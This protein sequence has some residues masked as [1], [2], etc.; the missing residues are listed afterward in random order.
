MEAKYKAVLPTKE[1]K[2][3]FNKVAHAVEEA[4]E[5]RDAE[6]ECLYE[7]IV[8]GAY[9]W[10]AP[11]KEE[12]EKR[13]MDSDWYDPDSTRLNVIE[14]EVPMSKVFM[15]MGKTKF[16]LYRCKEALMQFE[17]VVGSSTSPVPYALPKK[18]PMA[19][20]KPSAH[21]KEYFGGPIMVLDNKDWWT[22]GHVCIKGE[23]PKK[24]PIEAG[25]PHF[26]VIEGYFKEEKEE[27]KVLYYCQKTMD[28]ETV[29]SGSPVLDLRNDSC[30]ASP[31]GAVKCT[32]GFVQFNQYYLNAIRNRFPDAEYFLCESGALAAKD[33]GEW[34]AV[35]MPLL[36]EMEL[37]VREDRPFLS[38]DAPLEKEAKEAGLL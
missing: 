2:E 10:L 13:I 12:G 7:V 22:N 3:L 26:E 25:N 8:N 36:A 34:V 37:R 5:F 23:S 16:S 14:R 18:K 9:Y 17:K 28:G 32:D 30:G 33:N 11:S 21:K 35:V 31:I 6:K 27:V 4:P 29:I 38:K 20:P 24:L 19:V 15:C 1:K